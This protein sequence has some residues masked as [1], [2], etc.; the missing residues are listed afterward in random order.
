MRT[1]GSP[2]EL[3]NRRRLAVQRFLEGATTQDI[4]DFLGVSTRAVRL[5]VAAFQDCGDDGLRARPIPGRPCKLTDEQE[6]TVLAWLQD[7]ATDHSFANELW[8]AARVGT[9]IHQEWGIT[10]N[11]RYLSA[12]LRDRDITPQKPQ[13]VPRERDPDRIAHW[14]AT[15]WPRLKKKSAG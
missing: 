14:R 8:T 2:T 10:F 12:W 9:L 3:E 13:R 15:D 1:K 5:W 6:Q 4:A 11:H 7:S